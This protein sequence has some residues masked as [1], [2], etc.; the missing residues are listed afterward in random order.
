MLIRATGNA[1]L[2]KF[3]IA[4]ALLCI[5]VATTHAAGLQFIE[6]PADADEPVNSTSSRMPDTTPFW[7]L[8]HQSSRRNSPRFAMIP[9]SIEW[10]SISN[11]MRRC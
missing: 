3:L 8:A 7:H 10:H 6:V 1:R 5:S 4:T 11:S 2:L 9:G